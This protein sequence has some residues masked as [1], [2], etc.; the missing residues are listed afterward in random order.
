[1]R[2]A[3][4]LPVLLAL[5]A[6]P[7]HAQEVVPLWPEGAMPNTRGIDVADSVARQRIFQIA[8]PELL[9][10]FPSQEENTRSAVVILP[11]GG[12]HH[13][14][15]VLGGT[16]LAKWFNT[17]GVNAFVLN[18]RL[19]HSPDLEDRTL[20][21]LQDA[22]RA[23]RLVRSRAEEWGVD[24]G[25]VG[26]V[27]RSAGGHLA[28]TLGTHAEDVSAVGDPLDAQPFAPDFMILVSP[29]VTMGAGTHAGSRRNLLGESPSPELVAAYSNERRVTAETPPTFLVH[30]ADDEAVVPANSIAFYEAL[31]AHG[32]SASLHVFPQGGHAIGLRGSPGSTALWT[33]LCEGWLAERGLLAPAPAP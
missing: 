3:A 27:G 4:L 32:V 8:E 17:L 31:L 23:L 7:A 21:P 28:T 25:R 13:L 26:V 2:T 11:G 12:Y 29:V 30:A 18:Y 6:W 14:T 10:F 16:Q 24:P 19:P 1:M 22:Q 33:A 15:Y 9:A 5:A 20:G